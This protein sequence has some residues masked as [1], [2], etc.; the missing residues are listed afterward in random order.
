MRVKKYSQA[1]LTLKFVPTSYTCRFNVVFSHNFLFFQFQLLLTKLYM[2]TE[3]VL[4]FLNINEQTEYDV[5][6]T[7]VC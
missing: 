5:G 2:N 3:N 7:Y 4:Y 6:L 1:L